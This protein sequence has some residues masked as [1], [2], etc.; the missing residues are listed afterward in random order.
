VSVALRSPEVGARSAVAPRA[1]VFSVSEVIADGVV[2]LLPR[3]WREHVAIV[4]SVQALAAVLGRAAGLPA[5]IDADAPDAD[6]AVRC[7]RAAGAAAIVLLGPVAHRLA[8]EALEEADAIIPRDEAD[9]VTLRIALAACRAGM[10]LLPRAAPAGAQAPPGA[11]AIVLTESARRALVL[12]ADGMRDA[13]IA[14]ELSLSE[15]AVRKLVQRTV[16]AAGARTRC[17]AVAIASRSRGLLASAEITGT[18]APD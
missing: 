3:E 15:S 9:E 4:A 11:A 16:R 1:A 7:V 14:R 2:E 13:E 17:Q 10:R 18:A 6:E 12:L 5:I 8:T